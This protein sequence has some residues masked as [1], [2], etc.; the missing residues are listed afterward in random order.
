MPRTSKWNQ[1]PGQRVG[2]ARLTGPLPTTRR[3]ELQADL[4]FCGGKVLDRPTFALPRRPA[5]EG[6]PVRTDPG[7]VTSAL[8]VRS[9][10]GVACRIGARWS[11]V[12]PA[13]AASVC[14]RPPPLM[15]AGDVSRTSYALMGNSRARWRAWA[16]SSL[17][18]PWNASCR[19]GPPSSVLAR[20]RVSPAGPCPQALWNRYIPTIFPL[21]ATRC[22]DESHLSRDSSP[23]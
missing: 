16:R 17:R 10:S 6:Q 22:P 4:W 13:A 7:G 20:P 1:R 23:S 11:L 8:G 21:I 9:P 2:H 15:S 5:G 12:V 18:R 14:H 19:H 3:R